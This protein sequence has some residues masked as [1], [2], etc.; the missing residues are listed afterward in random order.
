MSEK[1]FNLGGYQDRHFEAVGA[2][3]WRVVGGR[4]EVHVVEEGRRAREQRLGA[5]GNPR[6]L[7]FC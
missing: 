7:T 6:Q 3:G 2:R 5:L 4:G 1:F